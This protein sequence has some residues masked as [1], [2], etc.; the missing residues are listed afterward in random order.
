M[1]L[2]YLQEENKKNFLKVCVHAALSNGIF[3][4]EEEKTLGAYCR[5]MNIKEW[6]PER[7]GTFVELIENIKRNTTSSE[8]NIIVIEILALLNS[9]GE[10]DVKE[11]EFMQSLIKGLDVSEERLEKFSE[12]LEQYTEIGKNMYAAILE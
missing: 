6:I 2:N 7:E 11:K 8:R 9:D 1:F 4:K 10:Y 12:L 5:E 3:A